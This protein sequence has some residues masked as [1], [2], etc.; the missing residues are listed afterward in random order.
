MRTYRIYERNHRSCGKSTQKTTAPNKNQ[1]STSVSAKHV[2]YT[3]INQALHDVFGHGG[4]SHAMLFQ[5][6]FH[7]LACWVVFLEKKKLKNL[8]L[9][10]RGSF[11]I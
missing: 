7:L 5:I 2:G 6:C 3:T 1:T 11:I 9:A 4:I 10:E 8:K